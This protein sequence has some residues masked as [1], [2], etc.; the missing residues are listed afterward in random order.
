MGVHMLAL[1]RHLVEA[2]VQVSVAYWPALPTEQLM[3]KAEG[4]G[5]TTV[6]TPHP[7]DPAYGREVTAY[8]RVAT[9]DVF[10]VH[11]GT[12]RED[13]G[14]ARAARAAGVPAVVE[15][16]HL[17]WMMRHPG[18]RQAFLASLDAVD[19]LVVVSDAQGRSYQR[20]GVPAPSLVTVCNGVVP[21]D[22]GPGRTEARRRLD[23]DPDQPVLMTVGRL[24]VQKGHRHLVDAL[25][26]LVARWP[27]L[28]AVVVG[29]G[30]LRQQLEDQA[31]ARGVRRAL[32]LVGH[33]PDARELLDAADVF[34]LPSRHEG[35]PMAALEAMDAGLP[36][37]ATDVTGTAEVVEDGTTG[38]LVRAGDSVGLADTL[39]E[40]LA[41]EDQRARLA[42]AGQRSFRERFT[43]ARMTADTLAVYVR[44]LE[45]VGSRRGVR[46]EE[47]VG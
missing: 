13:F 45:R 40:L 46:D 34:V 10:H 24:A 36:V 39:A 6:R 20:I 26:A 41:D 31:D 33:R 7:R 25:P 2:G 30:H 44:T 18:K 27:E 12:G 8:L 17:P 11:V 21:R 5:A 28:V 4:L 15:T 3:S 9:P 47:V 19:Q 1:V 22:P 16:L 35:M 14:G 43:A 37:V 23:L 42:A 32:R 38:R 29:D